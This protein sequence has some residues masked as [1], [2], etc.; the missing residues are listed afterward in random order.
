MYSIN[1]GLVYAAS[2]FVDESIKNYSSAQDFCKSKNDGTLVIVDSF[3]TA[4]G[5][6]NVI[7]NHL[8]A[9]NYQSPKFLVGL[10]RDGNDWS[11]VNGLPLGNFMIW[12]DGYPKLKIDQKTKQG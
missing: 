1:N 6:R 2:K 5:A 12:A 11:Y 3:V 4:E 9:Y 7:S 10:A 8:K